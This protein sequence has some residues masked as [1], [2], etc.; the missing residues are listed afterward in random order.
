MHWYRWQHVGLFGCWWWRRCQTGTRP[1]TVSRTERALWWHHHWVVG[2]LPPH[3]L[4]VTEENFIFQHIMDKMRYNI[5]FRSKNTLPTCQY[6][7]LTEVRS[8][9]DSGLD[10]LWLLKKMA[11]LSEMGEERNKFI[12]IVQ[13][14]HLTPALFRC[15]PEIPVISKHPPQAPGG[16]KA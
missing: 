16:S 10:T 5:T 7:K 4:S 3:S 6:W 12:R 13:G 15:L 9:E 14:A 8:E 2:K 1:E 11:F